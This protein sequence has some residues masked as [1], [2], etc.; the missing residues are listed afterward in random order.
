[1]QA[2]PGIMAVMGFQMVWTMISTVVHCSYAALLMSPGV[3]EMSYSKLVHAGYYGSLYVFLLPSLVCLL[4]YFVLRGERIA[5]GVSLVLLAVA[6]GGSGV[7]YAA[8]VSDG[9]L[10]ARIVINL[11]R[12]VF[13]AS[14][15]AVIFLIA[16]LSL[17][18]YRR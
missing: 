8:M 9:V 13:L 4:T 5:R 3:T 6:T 18:W 2:T 12:C 7:L 11:D 1:M 10:P 15:V 14:G 16:N 17:R